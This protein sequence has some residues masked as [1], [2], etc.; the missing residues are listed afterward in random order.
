[1]QINPLSLATCSLRPLPRENVA[2]LFFPAVHGGPRAHR[3]YSLGK[4]GEGEGESQ[5]DSY[6]GQHQD[7]NTASHI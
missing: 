2:K 5:D 3:R 1:M 4:Q 7:D 6:N